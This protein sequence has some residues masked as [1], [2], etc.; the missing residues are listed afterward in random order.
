MST[1]LGEHLLPEVKEAVGEQAWAEGRTQVS[2]SQKAP[3]NQLTYHDTTHH[4]TYHR[5][6]DGNKK[7]C[8]VSFH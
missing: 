4:G 6:K 1:V 8:D 5:L 2:P 7:S 3:S